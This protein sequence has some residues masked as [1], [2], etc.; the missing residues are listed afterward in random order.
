MNRV[1]ACLLHMVIP[2]TK[3]P[4]PERN[5]LRGLSDGIQRRQWDSTGSAPIN[6]I[7]AN[8]CVSAGYGTGSKYQQI[9]SE[10]LFDG[11]ARSKNRLERKMY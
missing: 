4:K 7:G 1:L 3:L 11:P 6:S 10:A 8:I 9:G 2:V 5:F